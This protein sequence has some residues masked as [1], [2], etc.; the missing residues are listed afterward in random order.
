V[1]R[2]ALGTPAL[3]AFGGGGIGVA[4][5][6]AAVLELRPHWLRQDAAAAQVLYAG[7]LDFHPERRRCHGSDRREV[8]YEDRCTVGAP[9]AGRP[10]VAV[11]GDSH[12]VELAHALGTAL[13]ERGG[14]VA[15]M[16]SSTCPPAVGHEVPGW[17]RCAALNRR[18]LADLVGDPAVKQVVLAA[19]HEHYLA[20]GAASYERGLMQT[21][22]ALTRAGKSVVLVGPVPTYAYPVPVALGALTRRGRDPQAF[23]QSRARY[24]EL[25]AEGIGVV[26][27]VAGASGAS[28]L[29]T[30]DLLCPGDVCAVVDSGRPLYFDDNHLSLHGAMVL[31]RRW[32]QAQPVR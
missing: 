25:Q 16:T 14:A 28:I 29:P 4:L 8:A 19:R 22:L 1:R 6:L 17:P 2:S 27:R 31:M 5:G 23:G 11:W 15:Q 13:A 30:G 3:L 26:E 24:L 18:V 20:Q 32:H 7:A 9:G 10:D 12:G 21:T